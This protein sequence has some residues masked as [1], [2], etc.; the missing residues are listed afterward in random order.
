MAGPWARVPRAELEPTQHPAVEQRAAM[1]PDRVREIAEML[2]NVL[3]A[4]IR[5]GR[6]YEFVRPAVNTT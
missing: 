5:D 1:S 4:L 2:L 6:W 3:W